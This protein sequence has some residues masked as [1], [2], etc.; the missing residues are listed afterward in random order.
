MKKKIIRWGILLL[1]VALCAV[2]LFPRSFSKTINPTED[3]IILVMDMGIE[4]GELQ[5]KTTEYRLEP[6]SPMFSQISGILDKYSYHLSWK[7]IA[8]NIAMHGN[9]PGYWLN[10]YSG[11]SVIIAGGT[12]EIIIGSRIYR[13]GYFGDKTAVSMMEDIREALKK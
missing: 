10:I 2:M 3:M 5:S 9:N 8:T 7:S 1:V 12:G 11:E 13:I 6:G 4:N